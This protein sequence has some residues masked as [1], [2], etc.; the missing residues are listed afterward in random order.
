M[1]RM[2][3][4]L[5][6][7]AACFLLAA[8][9]DN[10]DPGVPK[11]G[12]TDMTVM[13]Y[14]V[15]DNNLDEYLHKNI[16]MMC[17]GLQQLTVPATLL[18]YWDGKVS[19][20]WE[21]PCI[22]KYV[23]DGKGKVNGNVLSQGKTASSRSSFTQADTLAWE[24]AEVIPTLYTQST[25]KEQMAGVLAQ[26]V[27]LSPSSNHYGLIAGSHGS[28]WLKSITGSNARSFGQDG[29]TSSTISTG[30]MAAAIASAGKKMDFI[31]FDACMMGCA[32]VCYDFRNVAD[33]LIVSVVDIPAPGFPYGEMLPHLFSHTTDGYKETCSTY[34]N[35]YREMRSSGYWGT[36]SLIDCSE[37]EALASAVRDQLTGH[38]EMFPDY[39]PV[40]LQHYGLNPYSSNF[41]YISF[42]VTQFVEDLNG[43]V[44]PDAFAG[45]MG[46]TVIYTEYVENSTNYTIDGAHYCGLGMYVPVASKVYWNEYFRTLGWYE[47]A[48]WN[49]VER[50]SNE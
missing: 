47:A 24:A 10:D 17:E 41:K 20:Y 25:D 37:M 40:R 2:K 43:G 42:D 34:V 39:S 16:T 22:L 30:D 19:G 44:C 35:H 11:D 48:G 6:L 23:T 32:E 8:C 9:D 29:S 14:F 31:L 3:R 15:A 5:L 36:M 50:E 13:A 18:I 1:Y 28:G 45:Q 21:K 38:A 46:R 12:T 33:Y 4:L 27:G 49:L 26:M 7:G